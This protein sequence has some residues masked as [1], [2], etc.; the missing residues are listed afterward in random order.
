[1]QFSLFKTVQNAVQSI[2]NCSKLSKI[3][4]LFKIVQN[5]IK[6]I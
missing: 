5:A 1:M 4:S 6:S 2:Q 3:C